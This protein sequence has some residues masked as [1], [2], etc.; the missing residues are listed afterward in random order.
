MLCQ[1]AAA[2]ASRMRDEIEY[3]PPAFQHPRT[4][5]GMISRHS[6]FLRPVLLIVLF[7]CCEC[8]MIHAFVPFLDGGKDMPALYDAWFNKQISK[9]CST[10]IQKALAS[11]KKKLEV[12]FPPVP[13]VDEVKFG[14]PL[15]QK[16]GTKVVATDLNV[17]GGYRPGSPVSRNLISYSNIYW[18]KCLASSVAGFGKQCAVLTA[19]PMAFR[20][21]RSKGG[22][23][24]VGPLSKKGL[25]AL[26][27]STTM[28]SPVI[29]VNPGGEET[30]DQV[31]AACGTTTAPFVVLNNA[32]STTYDL[33]N[34]RPDYEEAYYLKRISKG[35]VFRAFPGPWQAYMERPDGTVELLKS[36][37]NKPSLNEVA[38]LVRDESFK[39]F[40]I[41]NDRF[42]K[43]F[44]GRL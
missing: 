28:N 29:V 8:T 43:G 16:F 2:Q 41:N 11:G 39:R 13:N 40:A 24:I 9:Q 22:L 23:S 33:G 26:Q 38:T 42:A 20:E 15:N 12:N 1:L 36:Y 27:Q 37:P 31:R 19:E 3:S 5:S 34:K 44:G 25:D 18:A 7:L 10:A 14:T 32:Y 30:W 17:P 6:S 35:W 4:T 21:I